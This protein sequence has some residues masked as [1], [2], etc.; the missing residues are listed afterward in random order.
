LFNDLPTAIRVCQQLEPLE[1]EFFETPFPVD[2]PDAYARLASKTS[3]PLAMGEHGV[4]RWEFLEMMDRGHV[5][6]VQ[7]Y[8]STCGGF[9]EAKRIV[10]LALP[11]GAQVV[12]GNWSTQILG[13]SSVHLAAYSP[14]TPLIEFAPAEVFDSPLRKELQAAGF[15][16]QNGAINI[17]QAPG[18]GYSIPDSLIEAF[19][20]EP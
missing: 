13:S 3:I 2:T 4:T 19:R 20:Q 15:P 1:L 14:I 18:I 8:V 7:P 10:E 17:P 9:T 12:P 11:R 16:V 5:T 6:V